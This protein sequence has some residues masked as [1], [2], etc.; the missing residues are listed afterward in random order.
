MSDEKTITSEKNEETS[1]NNSAGI[2]DGKL[3]A[4]LS[5][6]LIGVIWYFAD[7]KIKKND[8][9]KFHVKQSLLLIVASV[10]G[11][12]VLGITIVGIFLMPIFNLATFVLAVIGIVN[13]ANGDKKELVIIGQYANKYFKF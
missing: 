6:L 10:L 1:K 4:I 7:E 12:L 9:A 11:N 13:A 2:E 3:C 5:Y 8:F